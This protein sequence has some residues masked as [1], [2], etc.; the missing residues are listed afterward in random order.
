[1]ALFSLSAALAKNVDK[2]LV[3]FFFGQ[4]SLGIYAKM[5]EFANL[6]VSKV[7]G[8]LEPVVTR[9]YFSHRST[10]LA[11]IHLVGII[12]VYFYFFFF[13]FFD[14]ILSLIGES[15]DIHWVLFKR[16]LLLVSITTVF[17][18]RGVLFVTNKLN[19][20]YKYWGFLNLGSIALI[21]SMGKWLDLA[22]ILNLLV[23]YSLIVGPLIIYYASSS[24]KQT[25]KIL[26]TIFPYLLSLFF[27]YYFE[28]FAFISLTV[29][30]FTYFRRRLIFKLFKL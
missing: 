17:S 15:W 7:R 11:Y 28:E 20:Q 13:L 1:M 21:F 23:L 14:D 26:L 8:P 4:Y 18:I 16:I 5:N 12:V 10:L 3:L 30:F 29:T 9:L 22:T 2:W 27:M 25:K 24:L 6:V 19:K